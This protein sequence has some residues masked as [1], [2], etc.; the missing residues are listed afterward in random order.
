[1][2]YTSTSPGVISGIVV[3]TDNSTTTPLAAG[4]SFIGAAESLI[5][6]AELDINLAGTPA[7]APGTLF[8]EFS[9]DGVNWDVS[10][11]VALAGPSM[12][13][14]YLRVV[15]PWIVASGVATTSCGG[16]ASVSCSKVRSAV[17]T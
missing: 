7:V 4:A 3:S 5:S 14:Q 1:M 9:P 12:V 15:L 13:P 17:P 8:F 6:Y 2:A 16:F 11:P 10:V